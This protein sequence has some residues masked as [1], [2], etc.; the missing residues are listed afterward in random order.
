MLSMRIHDPRKERPSGPALQTESQTPSKGDALRAYAERLVKLI[1]AE[2]T[3]LYTTGIA[4]AASWA[5]WWGMVCLALVIL[6]RGVT[7]AEDDRGPQVIAVGI[8]CVS[9]IIWVYVS[10]QALPYLPA[11]LLP[12]NGPQLAIMVWTVA[13]PYLYRGD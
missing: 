4:Y 9:F 12:E 13:L 10:G 8:S 6:I 1:P 11:G 5:D 3:V 7:T 2:V